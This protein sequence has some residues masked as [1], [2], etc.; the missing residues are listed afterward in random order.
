M[1][2]GIWSSCYSGVTMP[3]CPAFCLS[4]PSSRPEAA[5]G[6]CSK[7]VPPDLFPGPPPHT[8]THAPNRSGIGRD[9]NDFTLTF[10]SVRDE[11]CVRDFRE[12]V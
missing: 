2:A 11:D 1:R 4:P 7:H 10:L 5:R 12:C 8:R 9:E 3:L 6:H